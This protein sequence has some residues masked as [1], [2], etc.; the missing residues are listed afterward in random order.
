MIEKVIFISFQEKIGNDSCN[1]FL[2]FLASPDDN[3]ISRLYSLPEMQGH[4]IGCQ[5][6]VFS[7]VNLVNIW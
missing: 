3:F 7:K 4:A 1:G 5:M 6:S 2:H